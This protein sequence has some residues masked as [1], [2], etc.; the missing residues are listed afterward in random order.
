[1]PRI[2]LIADEVGTREILHDLGLEQAP[3]EC[4]IEDR[5]AIQLGERLKTRRFRE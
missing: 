3:E 5:G 2:D 1:M 4:E